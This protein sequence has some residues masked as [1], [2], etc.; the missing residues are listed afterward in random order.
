MSDQRTDGA[1][2]AYPPPNFPT[3]FTD[4]VTNAGYGQSLVRLF[5]SR[6]DPSFGEATTETRT[7][8]IAQLIMPLDGFITTALFF[9]RLLAR[10]IAENFVNQAR[11]DEL[12]AVMPGE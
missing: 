11:I 7:Q 9:E 1:S 8:P 10:L 2:V 4:G 12:R 3:M 6:S 5:L